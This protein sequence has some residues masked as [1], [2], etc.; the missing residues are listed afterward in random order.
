MAQ[1][2]KNGM[3]N[4]NITREQYIK[5]I[6]ENYCL[7]GVLSDK[8]DCKVMHIRHRR[9]NRDIILRS[10]LR[11]VNA[12]ESLRETISKNLPETY[13]VINLVDGQIVLEEFIKGLTVADVMQSGRYRYRG[14]KRVITAVCEALS[15]LH[16]KGIVHRDVKPENI[17]I[18]DTGR[19]VL[20]DLN[21]SRIVS[22]NTKDTVVMGTV[23]Y[24]SPEQLGIIASDART[25]IYAVGVLLNVMLTGKH[26]SETLARGKAGKIVRKCTSVNPNERYQSAEKLAYAL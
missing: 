23:G 18:S 11:P 25:D 19:V 4:L 7:V 13:E 3:V 6:F 2:M 22:T 21:I 16:K 20:I 17:I 24:A 12:Y 15:I 10:F 1:R 9:L 26:P 5:K 8:N 14:A